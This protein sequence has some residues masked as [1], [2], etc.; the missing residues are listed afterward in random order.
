[1]M[2][3]KILLALAFLAGS[4]SCSGSTS[5]GTGGASG[6]GGT[7]LTSTSGTS[8]SSTSGGTSLCQTACSSLISCGTPAVMT[9]C[10]NGCESE[11][12][13][14]SA[15]MTCLNLAG[16]DCDAIALCSLKVTAATLCPGGGGVPA[17][18]ETCAQG[19]T[20]TAKCTTAPCNCTCVAELSPST[21]LYAYNN[22]VCLDGN[23]ASVC[24]PP[25][26]NCG[27]C[28]A[29]NCQTEA[30]ACASH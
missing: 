22:E 16:T 8:T 3:R 25:F 17:G 11:T 10:V 23:C 5:Q 6:A 29:A 7:G 21:A 4:A 20:C 24:T 26:T 1:M 30:A 14:N 9:T 28:F 13:V 12:S 15:F 2:T 19:S 18:T 27:A